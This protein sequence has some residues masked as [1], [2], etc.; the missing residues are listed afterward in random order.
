[1]TLPLVVLVAV[2]LMGVATIWLLLRSRHA[3]SG[4]PTPA[5]QAV[6]LDRYRVMGRILAQEDIDFV[7]PPGRLWRGEPKLVLEPTAADH[8]VVPAGTAQGFQPG[9]RGLPLHRAVRRRPELRVRPSSAVRQV[10][11]RLCPSHVAAE[12]QPNQPGAS[13]HRRTRH[14]APRIAR[15]R[16]TSAPIERTTLLS[17]VV[18]RLD[19]RFHD[20]T[21]SV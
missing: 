18:R 15:G 6:G 16:R 13:R 17:G 5:P 10:L 21:S 14:G 3:P 1:M 4:D 12:H 11:L 2:V 9:L 7:M 19:G 20:A 8:E